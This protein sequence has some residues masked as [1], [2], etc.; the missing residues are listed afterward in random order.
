VLSP[1]GYVAVALL[2]VILERHRYELVTPKL[3]VHDVTGADR[4]VSTKKLS[5]YS[6]HPLFFFYTRMAHTS[7][8][9][10]LDVRNNDKLA[11]SE[12]VL[13]IYP[14]TGQQPLSNLRILTIG[15]DLFTFI[16]QS[17]DADTEIH[18]VS[19]Q[20]KD[21][22]RVFNTTTWSAKR[23]LAATFCG[24]DM[25]TI[26]QVDSIGK[27]MI[28][29]LRKGQNWL[30]EVATG[31]QLKVGMAPSCRQAPGLTLSWRDC[32]GTWTGIIM[33]S[34]SHGNVV[35]GTLDKTVDFVS[36]H[37]VVRGATTA[38]TS[39]HVA[40]STT[41]CKDSLSYVWAEGNTINIQ[42]P[43][44]QTR[45]I[46]QEASIS[47]IAMASNGT[48]Y[49][50]VAGHLVVIDCHGLEHRPSFH[51]GVRLVDDV[52]GE[53]TSGG[54]VAVACVGN[55]CEFLD[56]FGYLR[57][58]GSG[59]ALV[60]YFNMIFNIYWGGGQ[61]EPSRHTPPS[62]AH[63]SFSKSVKYVE[64][65]EELQLLRLGA[66]TGEAEVGGMSEVVRNSIRILARSSKHL[67]EQ[68]GPSGLDVSVAGRRL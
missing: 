8:E 28:H 11:K 12:I 59:T 32:S 17:R 27:L 63:D 15:P 65:I 43:S 30:A 56:G 34:D 49:A 61:D 18:V 41:S 14:E 10:L 13:T 23:I 50:V 52:L 53:A 21:N 54:V 5:R 58:L 19:K 67:K 36:C 33:L 38:S 47:S 6:I 4:S 46:E 29:R 55:Q 9:R 37:K 26:E 25:V 1:D 44:M 48:V 24:K 3:T 57:I 7:L 16:F 66:T 22:Q 39:V 60:N 31:K 64:E 40:M 51:K 62:S 45:R 2:G 35:I 20:S 42:L 68:W